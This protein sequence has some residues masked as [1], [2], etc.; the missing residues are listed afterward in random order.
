MNVSRQLYELQSIELEIES[1]EQVLDEST[2]QLG[3]SEALV[4]ARD[5]F[6]TKQQY[7]EELKGK[8][9]SQEW[10]VDDLV[11]KIAAT[12]K[13]L[14][15]GQIKNS[16]ELASLQHEVSGLEARRC[17]LEDEELEVMDQVEKA[18]AKLATTESGL[19]IEEDKWRNQ[20]KKLSEEIERLKDE[21]SQLKHERQLSLAEI[22]PGTVDFYCQL[23]KQKGQSV[24]RIEQGT[25]GGC[26]L[27]LSTAELQRVR[28]NSLVHCSSCRRILFL[29]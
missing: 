16:K 28:G 3:E 9:Q 19:R 25:C 7:L 1:K 4:Q 13:T 26:R 17:Q 5:I 2:S 8:Q 21:L 15:S 12:K 6:S 24:A 10:E 23:K 20:Q 27:S 29:D 11:A 18:T 22:D 14:Y